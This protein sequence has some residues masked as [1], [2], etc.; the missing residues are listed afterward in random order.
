MSAG[1]MRA[2]R[3]EPPVP[4]R[5][6]EP[7]ER[8]SPH[9][10]VRE[11][12]CPCCGR[13]RVEPLLIRLLEELRAELGRPIRVTSG[14]RCPD[15]NRAVG[16]V[17]RSRHLEGRAVDLASPPG[18]QARLI[19]RARRIGFDQTIAYAGRGFVHLGVPGIFMPIA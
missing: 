8:L 13:I 17:P 16:G 7:P 2:R 19:A 11:L 6:A 12:A 14:Y 9:F 4:G 5:G 1:E 18:E 3:K 15:H 10:S